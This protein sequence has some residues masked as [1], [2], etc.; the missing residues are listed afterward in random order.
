MV[1][2]PNGQIA[3]NSTI[4][5]FS[6]TYPLKVSSTGGTPTSLDVN[7][8]CD[9]VGCEGD[10]GYPGLCCRS[11]PSLTAGTLTAHVDCATGALQLTGAWG[12]NFED[13]ALQPDGAC[14]S[15]PVEFALFPSSSVVNVGEQTA[16]GRP[17]APT[18]CE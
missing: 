14:F 7:V 15:E 9:D 12:M 16:N 17:A 18:S 5:D 1:S 10:G 6:G 3:D 8:E 2:D 11:D 13:Q 4:A